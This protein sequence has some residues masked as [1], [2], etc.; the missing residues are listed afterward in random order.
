RRNGGRSV[1]RQICGWRRPDSRLGA[2]PPIRPACCRTQR[3]SLTTR[4]HGTRIMSL[5]SVETDILVIGGGM[6]GFSAALEAAQAGRQVILLEKQD[7]IGGSSAMSGGC[8]AFAGTDLQQA[9]G[10]DDSAELLFTDLR[11]VGQFEN[12]E[13][14]VQVYVDNQLDTY[15]WLTAAGVQF[16]RHVEASSGQSV[17]RVHN[18][19]PADAVR[20]LAARAQETGLAQVITGAAAKR[21]PQNKDTGRVDGASATQNGQS[22]SERA[23]Q[24]VILARTVFART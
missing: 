15:E 6:A 16:G 1:L 20:A 12:D 18:V 13:A 11:E 22:M 19:D 17:P 4:Q 2:G 10:I 14:L 7:D 5:E 21:L 8:L 24:V 23:R 9:E 3:G